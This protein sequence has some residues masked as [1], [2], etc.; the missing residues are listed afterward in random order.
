MMHIR[1]I[2]SK[3]KLGK[4]FT[5]STGIAAGPGDN[6]NSIL[7]HYID[8]KTYV[9]RG[10]QYNTLS[11]E[12]GSPITAHVLLGG[13]KGHATLDMTERMRRS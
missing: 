1:L 6:A 13:T 5:E 7:Q 10:R 3:P 11:E 9:L 12:R 2:L 4:W 8:Q